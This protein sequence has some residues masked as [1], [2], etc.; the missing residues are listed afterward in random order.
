MEETNQEILC[1]SY[2]DP[3]TITF[4]SLTYFSRGDCQSNLHFRHLVFLP[5]LRNEIFFATPCKSQQNFANLTR[6]EK[7]SNFREYDKKWLMLEVHI[8]A[9]AL[10]DT[11]WLPPTTHTIHPPYRNLTFSIFVF[12]FCSTPGAFGQNI[13]RAESEETRRKTE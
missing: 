5:K 4:F 9:G 11:T 3:F 13:V 7:Y 8:V 10:F 2:R 1:K 12:P 6:I